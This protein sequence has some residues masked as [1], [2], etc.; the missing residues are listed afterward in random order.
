M[1][2]TEIIEKRKSVRSYDGNPLSDC[3]KQ[4]VADCFPACENPFGVEVEFRLLSAKEH[5]LTS[6]VLVGESYY[7]AAKAKRE[8]GFELGYGYSFE[9]FCLK[10][11]ALKFGTVMIAGTFNRKEFEAAMEVE[12]S[13]C[14]PLATP[15]GRPAKKK[16]M[17]EKMMR[18]AVGADKR[19]PFEELF[20][21]NSFA[22]PLT[23]EKAGA[24]SSALEMLRLA[25]SAVNKQP[26]RVVKCGDTVHFFKKPTKSLSGGAFDLQKVDMGIALCHFDLTLK[27]AGITGSFFTQQ[28]EL[29]IPNDA[30][31][32]ISYK[33]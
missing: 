23:R 28:P 20:F 11:A 13:E 4:A 30:E 10:A 14:M 1:N 12:D 6:P 22:T 24:F 19:L 27:E 7:V 17:R 33:I 18:K 21:E 2:I 9:L 29:K 16:S 26:W 5:K 31:Y 8:D 32:I 15:I 25:P 3:D